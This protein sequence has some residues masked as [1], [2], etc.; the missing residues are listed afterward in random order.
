MKRIAQRVPVPHRPPPT[1]RPAKH[2]AGFILVV[3]IVCLAMASVVFLAVLRTALAEQDAMRTDAWLQQ[4]GWLAESGIER[5]AARLAADPAYAGETWNIPADAFRG[6]DAAVVVIEVETPTGQPA[7]RVIRVRA[8]YPDAPR[9][10]GR[11]SK[12]RSVQIGPS[13]QG[14]EP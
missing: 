12:Q 11:R 2:R 8:D 3:A 4:A 1:W 7:R 14:N 6:D 5:A 9:H 10:R 13:E